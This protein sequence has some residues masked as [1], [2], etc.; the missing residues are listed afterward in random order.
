MSSM[1]TL[2]FRLNGWT[3]DDLYG[4]P[5]D[6][7]LRYELVDGALLVTPPP[8]LRHGHAVVAIS[9]V[10]ASALP[11]TWS[12]LADVGVRFDDRNYR[13]PDVLVAA[14]AALDKDMA[15]P[16]DVLLV[17]EVMSPS[18]VSNDRVSKP[19]L[20]AG[21]GIPHYWRLELEEHPVLITHALAGDTYR[22]S[23]RFTEDVAISDPVVVSFP[24]GALFG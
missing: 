6:D 22:E 5:D 2:P 1:T 10:L 21:A 8:V 19:A 17:V 20:Y 3:V 16:A 11:D 18:S 14:T 9:R 7:M 15:D 24:L 12:V 4:L 23:G 13:Q